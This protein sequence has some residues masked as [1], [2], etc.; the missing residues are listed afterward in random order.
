[1]L[2][3][4]TVEIKVF[5]RF[6]AYGR[7]RSWICTNKLRIRIQEAQ[8]HTDSVPDPEHFL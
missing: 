1:M 3:H 4:K 8:K 2:I 5:L 7:I 6:Y